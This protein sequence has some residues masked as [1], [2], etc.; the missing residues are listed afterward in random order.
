M[1]ITSPTA[2]P[3]S[4]VAKKAN[5]ILKIKE[6]ETKIKELYANHAT[7]IN[8]LTTKLSDS[9]ARCTDLKEQVEALEW[10][11]RDLEGKLQG[12][13][14]EM[15]ECGEVRRKQREVNDYLAQNT[16]D[17]KILKAIMPVVT[18][19]PVRKS[20]KFDII[21]G[22]WPSE[23]IQY[24]DQD[25]LSRTS[26]LDTQPFKMGIYKKTMIARSGNEEMIPEW[27]I[28]V[29]KDTAFNK[30]KISLSQLPRENRIKKVVMK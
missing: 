15:K 16:Y 12:Q 14:E 5:N 27:R 21:Q 9:E 26:V 17:L 23:R 25:L 24:P 18:M 10:K 1:S 13:K 28:G 20:V 7:E 3:T 11:V 22:V 6:L 2:S 4:P 8:T 29:L 19:M 30:F